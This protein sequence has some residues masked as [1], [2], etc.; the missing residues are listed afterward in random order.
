MSRST[1]FLVAWGVLTPL[2]AAPSQDLA[3]ARAAFAAADRDAD[4]RLTLAEALAHGQARSVPE[5]RTGDADGDGAWSRDE[6]VVQ[7]R[8]KL[9]AAGV[10][11]GQDLESEASRILGLRRVRAVE[12]S[13]QAAGPAA[14][15]LWTRGE[16][17]ALLDLDAQFERALRDLED[18][19]AGRGAVRAD[20][21][22]VRVLWNERTSR[23]RALA[24]PD[25]VLVDPTARI[26]R[27]LVHLE[28][29]A[30]AGSVPRAAFAPLRAAWADRPRLAAPQG[31]PLAPARARL[32]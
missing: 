24:G 1:L 26:L 30:R 12:E 20:F 29:R 17:L 27:E 19:A 7:F 11:P 5:F 9:V 32:R 13:R 21:E 4:G 18:H 3:A 31:P 14:S 22:R 8:A 2:P 23:I 15:R 28:A 16:P 25:V 6:F 10:K